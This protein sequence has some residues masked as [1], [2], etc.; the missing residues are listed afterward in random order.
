[1]TWT[2][3]AAE[4]AD[5]DRILQV[6]QA[7]FSSPDRDAHQELEIVEHTWAREARPP[8]LELVATEGG[9]VVAHVLAAEGDLG[10]R[11][12]LGIAPL[13]VMPGRQRQGIGTALVVELLRRADQG[14]WPL[15]VV[16]GDPRYYRRFGFEPSRP[17]GIVYQ[18]AGADS[19]HFQV[20]WLTGVDRSLAGQ[21]RYCWEDGPSE[22]S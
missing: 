9:V 19:P 2:I 7:A 13:S 10:G 6:V 20:R 21:F 3:R 22:L 5:R 15:V 17:F 14:G 18:P 16:L 8:G 12:V 11:R 1:M 4:P